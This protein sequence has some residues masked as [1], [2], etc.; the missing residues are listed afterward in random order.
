MKPDMHS[1]I[2]TDLYIVYSTSY[3]VPVLYFCPMISTG[4]TLRFASLDEC[5]CAL[6]EAHIAL[7]ENP[8]NGLVMYF[9]HPCRTAVFMDEVFAT[10][11][12]TARDAG[13]YIRSWL[14]FLPRLEVIDS[15]FA[16]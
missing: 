5:Q 4:D 13:A 6:H 12:S 16:E 8:V 2:D 7:G 10:M 14:S 11:H 1:A 9:V 3:C 15:M